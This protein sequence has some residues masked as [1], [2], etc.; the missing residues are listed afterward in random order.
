MKYLEALSA[1][2]QISSVSQG[3]VINLG[4]ECPFVSHFYSRS[5][6]TM[7]MGIW[8]VFMANNYFIDLK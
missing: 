4:K 2:K 5:V 1:F 8:A 6:E 7:R 3:E